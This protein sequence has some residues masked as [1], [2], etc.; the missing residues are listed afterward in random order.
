MLEKIRAA[1]RA[2]REG[3]AISEPDEE[4]EYFVQAF[5]AGLETAP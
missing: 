5:S 3:A 4:T 2:V 1:E